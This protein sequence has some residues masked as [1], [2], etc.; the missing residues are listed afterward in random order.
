LLHAPLLY[1]D[2]D[3]LFRIAGDLLAGRE[4]PLPVSSL[5]GIP[6]HLDWDTQ[7]SAFDEALSAVADGRSV[8]A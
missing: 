4:R 5:K 1:D 6:A 3:H 7:V 2:E 8:L